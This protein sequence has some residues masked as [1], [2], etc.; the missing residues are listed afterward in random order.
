MVLSYCLQIGARPLWK[1]Y[2]DKIKL[3]KTPTHNLLRSQSM[4]DGM[5]MADTQLTK[6]VEALYNMEDLSMVLEYHEASFVH[7]GDRAQKALQNFTFDLWYYIL[8]L[9]GKRGS[10]L[11]V[12]GRPPDCY[13]MI[14]DQD[15]D[16]QGS[17]ELLQSD[18]KNL[19]LLEQSTSPQCSELASDLGLAVSKPTRLIFQLFETGMATTADDSFETVARHKGGG[20]HPAKAQNC[21]QWQ[22]QCKARLA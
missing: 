14:T 3:T 10:T 6:L 8:G 15:I 18:W 21:C 7:L 13:A 1:W 11:S 16:A 22:C 20:G 12:F 5:W 9:L 4:A 19:M 2:S 17:F